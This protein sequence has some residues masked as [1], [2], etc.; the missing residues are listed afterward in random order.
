MADVKAAPTRS[1]II[2]KIKSNFKSSKDAVSNAFEV[3]SDAFNDAIKEIKNPDERES[4]KIQYKVLCKS[5]DK[6]NNK[7]QE[8]TIS[9]YTK[10]FPPQDII[11]LI[12]DEFCNIMHFYIFTYLQTY[13]LIIDIFYTI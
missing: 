10:L 12:N 5:F 2:E 9:E 8:K 7:L 11:N 6:S 13:T 4:I 3:F 1:A